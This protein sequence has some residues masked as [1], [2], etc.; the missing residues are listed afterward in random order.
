MSPTNNTRTTYVLS[1][2]CDKLSNIGVMN[3]QE[4]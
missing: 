1:Y 4:S 3:C 2:L